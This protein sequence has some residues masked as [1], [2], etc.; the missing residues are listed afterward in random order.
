[1]P[2]TSGALY[3]DPTKQPV[4]PGKNRR[5]HVAVTS[6]DSKYVQWQMRVMYYWYKKRKAEQGPDGD[7]GGFTRILHSGREDHLM[8]EIP[9]VVVDRLQ[10]EHGFVVLS[11]PNAF[12]QWLKQV[13]IE[14]DYVLM[15][16]PDHLYLRPIPNLMNGDKPAAFPFFYISPKDHVNLIRKY[17]G[18]DTSIRDIHHMDPIGSSPVMLHKDD[19][20]R[21]APM[22]HDMAVRMKTDPEADRAWGW[23]LEMWA[24][25]CA[26]WLTGVHHDLVPKLQAQPPWDT[27]LEGFYIL[28]YTYGNDY[29]RSGKFTPGKIG[30]W[31]FDKRSYM[32]RIPAKNLELPP[33][34]APESVRTLIQMINEASSVLPNWESGGKES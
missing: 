29:T 18:Q 10:N 31:R 33:K 12:V 4:P 17:V 32:G 16:E 1:M 20:A 7:M 9:T 21:V 8:H 14:E 27:S 24:Y 28:H 25:T 23:V 2:W 6:N 34:G 22:W 15:S 11:R 13:T 19:L 5:F 3:K 30:E 26:A